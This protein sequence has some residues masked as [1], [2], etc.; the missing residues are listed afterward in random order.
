MYMQ[1]WITR[2]DDFLRM[3][4]NEILQHAGTI[5]YDQAV[6][7]AE[8]EYAKYKERSKDELSKV[9]EDFVRYID[10]TAKKLENK[11]N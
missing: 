8:L 3:I 2:L 7:K 1:D 5:S 10:Q 11:K 4:G 6:Q 9:E